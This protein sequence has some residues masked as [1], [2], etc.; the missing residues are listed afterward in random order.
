MVS[1]EIILEAFEKCEIGLKKVA[2]VGMGVNFDL[3][4]IV[5]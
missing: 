2:D 1:R 4:K 5:E 3:Y